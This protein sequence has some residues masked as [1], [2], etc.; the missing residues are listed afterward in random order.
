MT[1]ARSQGLI[2]SIGVANFREGYL[3]EI[4]SA[5]TVLPAVNQFE[6]HPTFQPRAVESATASRGI[7]TE[8][9]SPLGL[10]SDLHNPVITDIAERLGRTPAQVI[11]RWHM[12]AGRIVIPKSA[13][14]ARIV[15]NFAVTDFTLDREDTAA[16]DGLDS[17]NV[18]VADPEAL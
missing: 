1:E 6:Y 4:V 14:P 2:G 18:L 12:Q 11:L 8:A 13:T 7:T 10:G 17:G 16:I 9:Y 3:D 15:E 5:G